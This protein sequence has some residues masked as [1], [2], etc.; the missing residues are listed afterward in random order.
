MIL[1]AEKMVVICQVGRQ[2]AIELSGVTDLT[3]QQSVCEFPIA[4][5][6]RDLNCSP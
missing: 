4:L 1:R 3:M 5:A 6:V 2:V